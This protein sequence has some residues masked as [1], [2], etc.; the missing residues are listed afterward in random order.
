MIDDAAA[1]IR[2]LAPQPQPQ[3]QPQPHCDMKQISGLLVLQAAIL[4]VSGALLHWNPQWV[5]AVFNEAAVAK[6]TIAVMKGTTHSHSDITR[7]HAAL[8]GLTLVDRA[9]TDRMGHDIACARCRVL[10][11]AVH[12]Q[13]LRQADHVSRYAIECHVCASLPEMLADTRSGPP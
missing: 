9:D 7:V 4:G 5:V 12:D 8:R 1:L 10:P 3:P 2:Y 13:L 11:D 6:D